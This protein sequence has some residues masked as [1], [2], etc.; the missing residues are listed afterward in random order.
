MFIYLVGSYC[1]SNSWLIALYLRFWAVSLLSV[2]SE[3]YCPVTNWIGWRTLFMVKIIF[4]NYLFLNSIEAYLICAYWLK[5]RIATKNCKEQHHIVFIFRT[6]PHTT[7]DRQHNST[8][9][10]SFV[11]A[12]LS[13]SKE[14][15]S[16]S[17]N[18]VILRLYIVVPIILHILLLWPS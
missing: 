9:F 14:T 8:H 5:T 10:F 18:E 1:C 11:Y 7:Q 4:E 6:I 15:A 2:R 17:P 16:L 13:N 3:N 12:H